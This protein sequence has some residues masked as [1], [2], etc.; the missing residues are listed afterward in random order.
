[1]FATV[2]LVLIQIWMLAKAVWS[3]SDFE[4][5]AVQSILAS[6][7]TKAEDHPQPF[8]SWREHLPLSS[9]LP[10]D[11]KLSLINYS[12]MTPWV[13]FMWDECCIMCLF[14]EGV[15]RQAFVYCM[16]ISW[17]KTLSKYRYKMSHCT[18]SGIKEIIH[19]KMN[20]LLSEGD[21]LFQTCFSF[22]WAQKKI[23]WR[24]LVTEQL[25]VAIDSIV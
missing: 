4:A 11:D 1:M 10:S 25:M 9:A 15:I 18:I 19:P 7:E 12:L 2:L 17:M 14:N 20:I 6:L 8:P 23:F 5:A 3:T 16:T 24:T 21:H 13:D 22:C